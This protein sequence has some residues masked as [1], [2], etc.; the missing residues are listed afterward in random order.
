[1]LV[2][3][4]QKKLEEDKWYFIELYHLNNES[5]KSLVLYV[6]AELVKE[7][8]CKPYHHKLEYDE[9]TIGCGIQLE[10]VGKQGEEKIKNNFRGEMSALYFIDVSQKTLPQIHSFLTYISTHVPLENMVDYLGLPQEANSGKSFDVG[11]VEKIFMHINP[12]YTGKPTQSKQRMYVLHKGGKS[13]E[14]FN[15]VER[16]YQETKVEHNSIAKDVFLCIGGIKT[17]L[18][19]LYALPEHILAADFMYLFSC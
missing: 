7:A 10:Y 13:I 2:T 8:P 19:L 17:L 15:N 1:M 6:S 14:V 18:P 11:I 3:F 9:N 16:V 4:S 5:T 12:K